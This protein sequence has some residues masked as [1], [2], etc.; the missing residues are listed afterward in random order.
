MN[1][2]QNDMYIDSH[3]YLYIYICWA[4]RTA[5]GKYSIVVDRALCAVRSF[6]IRQTGMVCIVCHV[7]VGRLYVH[8]LYVYVII[9]VQPEPN[10][11]P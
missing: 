4:T 9:R 1:K 3:I 7:F 10:A 6:I 11:T 5:V 8:V 2:K